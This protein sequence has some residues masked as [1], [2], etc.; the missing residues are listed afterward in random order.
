M[1]LKLMTPLIVILLATGCVSTATAPAPPPAASMIPSSANGVEPNENLHAV[2]YLQSSAEA[3]AL[4]L[5][6]FTTAKRLLDQALADP[7]WNAAPQ[8]DGG[9]QGPPAVIAD[10]D[11]TLLSNA[12]FEARLIKSGGPYTSQAWSEWV[13]EAAAPP[14][15]GALEFARYAASRGVAV[16][17]VTNRKASEEAGTRKNLEKMGFPLSGTD[18]IL[19]RGERPEWTS[20]KT[21]RFAF[22][23]RDHRILLMLGDNL[24]DFLGGVDTSV[25]KRHQMV[26]QYRD[27]WGN[28]W[29]VLPN[30][31][32]GSWVGAALDNRSGL[33]PE[34]Q[35]QGK[36]DALETLEGP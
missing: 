23:A 3:E 10:V 1:R 24:G 5:G 16:Y 33:T 32:Y 20:D 35:L 12:A 18:T 4:S 19:T 30:P 31:M 7:S 11:E 28:R 26:L 36:I 6:T 14:I 25:E 34:Q 15:P 27:L 22:V 2:L 21:S 8:V 9:G 13:D 29:L 17:Y